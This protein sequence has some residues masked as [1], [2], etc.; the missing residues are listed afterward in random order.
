LTALIIAH[1]PLRIS[2]AERSFGLLMSRT[3]TEAR[4]YEFKSQD[5]SKVST[6]W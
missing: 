3:V 6:P 4:E 5:E 1:P 2:A